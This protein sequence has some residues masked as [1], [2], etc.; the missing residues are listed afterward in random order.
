MITIVTGPW[1]LP[2][3]EIAQAVAARLG[4][5]PGSPA[6]VEVVDGEQLGFAL[7]EFR[8][9]L[10]EDFQEDPVWQALF[11]TLCVHTARHSADGRVLAP[12]N[13]HCGERLARTRADIAARGAAVRVI[14]LRASREYCERLADTFPFFERDSP[15]YHRVRNWQLARLDAY[16][17]FVEDPA[18]PV[19]R[20][21]GLLPEESSE[22]VVSSIARTVTALSP[23][24]EPEPTSA[25]ASAS[26]SAEC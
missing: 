6:G 14:G 10:P 25:S 1:A 9:G 21:V 7:M 23:E 18:A 20:W 12:M 4:G 22:R 26:A 16:L 19:D 5:R 17:S 3:M 2:R 15:D 24:R 8:P 13:I 11:T